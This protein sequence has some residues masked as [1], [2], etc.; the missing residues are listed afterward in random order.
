MNIDNAVTT[1]SSG[2]VP[3]SAPPKE[4]PTAIALAIERALDSDTFHL[5]DDVAIFYDVDGLTERLDSLGSA[6]PSDTTHAIAIKANP[7]PMGLAVINDR[8]FGLEAASMGEL[9]L[10]LDA[11]VR[12]EKIVYDSPAKTRRDLR[13]ALELGVT[14]NA[15]CLAE[16]DRIADLID[17]G[18][19][20]TGLV[21]VR[22]NPGVGNGTIDE[23]STARATSKFGV[24]LD[25]H[26]DELLDRLGRHDWLRGLHVHIGSQGMALQQLV[27]GVG[28]VAELYTDHREALGL[29]AFNIG[30]GLPVK[31]RSTDPD[32]SFAAY[33]DALRAACPALFESTTSL[34]TE[35]GRS[36]HARNGWILSRIEYVLDH[37]DGIP[38]LVVHVGADMF[39]R[40]AY[41]P[42]N[43][44]HELNVVPSSGPRTKLSG[45]TRTYRVAG[46]LCFS[47][48]YLS[49]AVELPV[50]AA[51]G[52]YLVIRDAGAYTFSMWSTYN[53]RPFPAVIAYN[54]SE[55]QRVRPSQ[56]TADIV[57][58][59]KGGDETA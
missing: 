59:W 17:D 25:A 10:A 34:F 8:G 15:N 41:R 4:L 12:P 43:W 53:S 55:M 36:V 45:A 58:F 9:A 14:I 7:V 37:G 40:R 13:A 32:P 19:T 22:V 38:T 20:V 16:I 11:G 44:F 50:E 39:L 6:F 56:T 29:S 21:G 31:Y 3:E 33:A 47:G 28:R 30:G 42:E 24:S 35:F 23:T 49:R 26:G 46:P 52:D 1:G 27:D 2:F 54:A 5:S 57:R 51:E 48:D 18:A